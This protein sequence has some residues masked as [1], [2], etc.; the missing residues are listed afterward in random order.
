MKNKPGI[1][2]KKEKLLAWLQIALELEL[3][4]IPPYLVALLSIKLP[5]NR[6]SAELIR[7]V[8]IEE[9]LHLALV[10][11]VLNAVGGKPR[12][13]KNAIPRYPLKMK[14]EGKVFEDRKF[15]I[16][17]APFSEPVIKTFLQI[18]QPQN[19]PPPQGG[20]TAYIV[21]LDVPALTIGE[22]YGQIVSLLEEMEHESPGN[23]F[24]GKPEY[25]IKKDYY[26]A[27][28]GDLVV[29]QDLTTAKEALDLVIKQG[30]G[31]WTSGPGQVARDFN[32][33]FKIG[34]YYRFN[35]ILCGQRYKKSDN[36]ANPPTGDKFSVDYTNV[37]PLK[38]NPRSVDYK[39][40]HEL[41]DLNE[42]FNLRYS[43]MLRQIEEAMNGSPR[44]L[45]T[46][47]MDSMHHLTPIAHQ[48]M[49]TPILAGEETT[50]CPTFQWRE[51]NSSS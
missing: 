24:V 9:M 40:A 14:F 22:F 38:V 5:G 1:R 34:H 28:G 47:I 41:K 8:M 43:N 7:S 51:N 21:K 15:W 16:N 6:E 18:E 29:V 32:D 17:L 4:T 33:N 36:S 30:E 42:Q 31:A 3:S 13:D 25:Q 35:E 11:N 2:S 46:A 39:N 44:T 48:M 49:K 23:V 10:A 26:W 37:Y 12:L 50:G 27:G 45:Y 20:V 19:P